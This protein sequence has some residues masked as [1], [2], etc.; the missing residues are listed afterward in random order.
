MTG[1]LAR[2]VLRYLSGALVSYGVLASGT[3]LSLDPDLVLVLGVTLGAVAEAAY[4]IA[5]KRGWTL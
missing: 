3:D 2:I 5:K 4:A 1:A